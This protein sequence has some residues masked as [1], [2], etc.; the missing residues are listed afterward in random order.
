[1]TSANAVV[2]VVTL[3]GPEVRVFSGNS[4][5]SSTASSLDAALQAVNREEYNDDLD[6]IE[7]EIFKQVVRI[8]GAHF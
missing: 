5:S 7:G 3:P 2:K 6:D 1:M 4:V 8:F